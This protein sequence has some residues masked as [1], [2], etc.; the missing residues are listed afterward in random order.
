MKMRKKFTIKN[1]LL[2]TF[3]LVIIGEL[4][5]LLLPHSRNL[6][7]DAEKLI[8]QCKNTRD[9]HKCYG[10]SLA[11]INKNSNLQ[12]TL[13]LLD[14]LENI[15]AN[16]RDCHLLAHYIALS[17]VEKNPK[18][19]QDVLLKI[20]PNACTYGFVHG[21]LE[22]RT[23]FNNGAGIDKKTIENI[24]TLLYEKSKR[25]GVDESCSHVMGHIL[26]AEQRG[27]I[28]NSI[29]IC[30]LLTP[31]LQY[32]CYGGVFMENF[33][34]ENIV[35]HGIGTFIPWNNSLIL[36]QESL[37]RNYSGE[38]GK[39]C[40]M[41][42]AHLYASAANNKPSKIWE[43]CGQAPEKEFSFN[44]YLHAM[45][46]S[47]KS[48]STTEYKK[49]VC[50]PFKNDKQH[51]NLCLEYMTAALIVESTKFIGDAVDFCNNLWTKEVIRE[52][53]KYIGSA[54]HLY[55]PEREQE[56]LCRPFTG[57]FK[58]YCLMKS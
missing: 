35:A 39:A 30:D 26:L 20:D 14:K 24:C 46:N 32:M 29:A 50:T 12:Y 52:C 17:E 42:M 5:Y 4:F 21:T 3:V 31:R 1:L 23:R 56:N 54:L 53:Y 41:E 58:T 48:S 7:Q 55:V 6:S 45:G 37:C 47:I 22:G 9:W 18:K 25:A 16:T 36:Q 33:T 15:E 2:L 40:W 51:L 27:N 28:P 44:C 13:A 10:L 57:E 8:Q 43:L 34:R 49:E 11:V 38:E 19:W